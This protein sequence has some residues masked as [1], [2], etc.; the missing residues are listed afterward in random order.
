M[1]QNM[2]IVEAQREDL[3]VL[4]G[5]YKQLH[6]ND[7]VPAEEDLRAVWDA[8]L[9]NPN[10]T[11]LL[12]KVDGVPAASVSV[13]ITPNLTRGARPYALIENVITAAAYRRRGLAAALMAEAVK[14]AEAANCYKVSLTTG[15]KDAATFRFYESCGFNKEDKTAFIR[16]F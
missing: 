15:N 7:P 16:W 5:L 2:E 9:G 10:Y 11:V 12:A 13:I 8:V 6:P 14:I 3:P 4:M 1:K